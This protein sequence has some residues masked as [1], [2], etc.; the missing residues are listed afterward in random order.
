MSEVNGLVTSVHLPARRYDSMGTIAMTQYLSVC[1]C[2]SV[3]SQ[4]SVRAS[5]QVQLVS[6]MEA[7]FDQSY[8][9]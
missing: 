6:G 8:V 7:S 3:T 1:L 4:C 2:V 9:V 5:E